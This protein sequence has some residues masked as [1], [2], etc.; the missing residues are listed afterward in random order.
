M[1]HAGS[2]PAVGTMTTRRTDAEMV[3]WCI[4]GGRNQLAKVLEHVQEIEDESSAARR[5]RLVH[6][7]VTVMAW[8]NWAHSSAKKAVAAQTKVEE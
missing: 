7:S 5:A 8:L 1:D 4:E 3:L 6:D 2:I